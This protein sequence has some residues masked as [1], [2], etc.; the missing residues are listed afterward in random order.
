M[1]ETLVHLLNQFDDPALVNAPIIRWGAPVPSF[2]DPSRSYVATLGINPSNLEFMNED[3][4]ELI[5]GNRRFHT[6]SSLGIENWNSVS[7][8]HLRQI[9][10]SCKYYFLRNPYDRWFKKL[11]LVVSGS[12]TSYYDYYSPACHLDLVPYATKLKW[13]SLTSSQKKSLLLAC[14]DA[15][16]E[17]L[18]DSIVQIII[19]NG[20]SV[21][22]KFQ[23]F[24]EI[25]LYKQEMDG[26][27][28]PRNRGGSVKGYSYKGIVHYLR[29]YDLGREIIILGFNH[30][31]QSSFGVTNGVIRRIND[32]VKISTRGF[33]Q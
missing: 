12:G 4:E 29:G 8:R 15:L 21:V 9:L 2:G 30:N 23:E 27:D 33:Y 19:L 7:F 6:L 1:Y 22:E 16:I 17:L 26:W 20:K 14:Q 5:G 24:A 3:G 10:G 28:L 18:R 32:W 11:D 13:N 25:K 31:I